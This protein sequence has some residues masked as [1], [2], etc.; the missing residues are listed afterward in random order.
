MEL[1]MGRANRLRAFLTRF[2]GAP[3]V[4]GESDCSAAPALWWS[5]ETGRKID[6]PE[7]ASRD[8]AHAIIEQMGGL[9]AVWDDI[10]AQVGGMERIGEPEIGDVGIIETRLHGQIGGILGAGRILI[11]RKDNG[12][13]HPFGPVRQFLRVYETP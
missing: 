10:A 13:W 8:E 2:E 1:T 4:W 3:V 5:E 7:Y 6:L 12:S 9:L 11:I